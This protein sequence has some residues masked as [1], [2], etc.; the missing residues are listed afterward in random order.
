M[1]CPMSHNS[2]NLWL[3]ERKGDVIRRVDPG[4]VVPGEMGGGCA[5]EKGAE[6]RVKEI[7]K[8]A[9]TRRG[10]EAPGKGKKMS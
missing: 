5:E 1:R 9:G 3:K 6:S 2:R 10:T 8:G 7:K 4:N